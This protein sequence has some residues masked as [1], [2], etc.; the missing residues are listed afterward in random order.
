[1]L[2]AGEAV[3]DPRGMPTRVPNVTM[4]YT[5]STTDDPGDPGVSGDKAIAVCC[6]LFATGGAVILSS[7][8]C[9]CEPTRR[10]TT[11]LSIF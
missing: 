9:H 1:M 6:D 5:N 2:G 4:G 10:S 3:P 7:L 11:S 8:F